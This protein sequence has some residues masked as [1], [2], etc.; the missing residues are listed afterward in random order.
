M[1]VRL[2]KTILWFI[3]GT[4][5]TII[6]LRIL[7]G[8]GSVVALTD[9]LPW[10]LWKGGGVVALVPIGGAGF[11]VAALVYV[12]H[13]K[14]F[15]PLARPAVLLG[16]VCY[17]SVGA[18]L[19]IDIGIWWRIVF[20]V[21]FWNFHSTLFEVAWCIMLYLGVLSAEFSHAVVERFKM[22]K[23]EH[24]LE[25][26]TIIFVIIGISLST[27]H[28]SSLGTLFLATPYRLHPLW[29]T[30]I[31]PLLFFITSI[32]L[33][34][35]TISWVSIV[36]HKLYDVEVPMEAISGL[37]FLSMIFMG[38]YTA[39]KFGDILVAG[40]A[41]LLFVNNPDTYNFWLEILLGSLLPFILLLKKDL[42]ESPGAM[43]WI[44]TMA[45]VGISLNRVNVAG[46]ATLS[47]TSSLY[48][49][50]WTEWAVT[51]GILACAG[52]GYLFA[53]ENFNVFSTI[54]SKV[55]E[56]ARS[57]EIVDHADWKML[58]F[59]NPLSDV[60]LYSLVFVIAAGAVFGLA[61]NDAVFGVEPEITPTDRAR[62]V[63]VYA[64]AKDDGPGHDYIIP[65]LD[66]LEQYHGAITT[67]VLM[68]DGNRDGDYVLFDHEM[69][70]G[71]NG[72]KDDSCVLCHHMNKPYEKA[73]KCYDCHSDMYMPVYIFDHEYHVG[74]TG[75]NQHCT[76]CHTDL[77]QPKVRENAKP[78]E[79]CHKNLRPEGS[80]VN[81]E[82]P[83]KKYMAAGYMDAMHNLCIT[84]HK[85]KQEQLAD[86]DEN[87]GRC[88]T[89]HRDTPLLDDKV[90]ERRL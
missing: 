4:G 20:P 42:R 55:V 13:I 68:I 22:H 53:V 9:L 85:N 78:C 43:F 67:E 40:E 65:D 54:D 52:L 84:C 34:C 37:G 76:E 6:V 81:V 63:E 80:L 48:F 45:I 21:V 2:L 1:K 29:Y 60:R 11:T 23:I 47:L 7:N 24:L 77:S 50:A 83:H 19:T 64:V 86:R 33:G 41:G 30:E 15:E 32:G 71:K 82:D 36:V 74:K 87:F 3:A 5:L 62:T 16:L 72:G 17:S 51:F 58:F 38:I 12:F 35:L 26:V 73:S 44:A 39:L 31:L 14:L 90:W 28:Q 69:H 59:A 70:I 18:G 75:G 61:G 66:N 57:S 56:R 88:A 25:K 46:L 27:L 8:P 89:C 10:G 79:E 49:P